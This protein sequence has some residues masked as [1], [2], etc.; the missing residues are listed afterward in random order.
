[1][2]AGSTTD[3]LRRVMAALRRGIPASRVA[4]AAL[5]ALVALPRSAIP[6]IDGDVYWHIRAGLEVL[7]TG[8]VPAEDSWSLVGDG[9]R[10]LS[11]DWLSNVLLGLGWRLGEIGPSVL[12]LA[13]S[14]LVVAALALLWW[15]FGLRRPETGWLGRTGWLTVGL[16]V[17]GPVLGVRVQVV[18]LTLATAVVLSCW[19]YLA[20]PSIGWLVAL[21]TISL[22]WGNLHAG[23]PL[24]FLIG[25]AIVIGEAADQVLKRRPP[26]NM[27][28][29]RQIALLGGALVVSIMPIA[30]NPS[31]LELY[32]YPLETSSI[33]AHRDFISEWQ[34][35]DPGTIV[36]QMFIA[37]VVVIV[38]PS[39]WIG[40][41]T[42][43]AA[44]ALV[45]AGMTVMIALGARFQLLAPIIAATAG[46]ALEPVIA[47]TAVGRWFSKPLARL[48]TARSGAS[49]NVVN[50]ALIGIVVAAGLGVAWARV[51]PTA[52]RELVA[53]HM[54]VGAV[55]WIL[56][57]D[58]GTRPFNQYSWGGYLGL[59][60]PD[61]PIYIDG[62][63]DIY[64]DR[65]IREY[66]NA[67]QLETDPQE[68][69]DRYAIDYILFPPNQPLSQWLEDSPIWQREYVDA[70]AAVWIRSNE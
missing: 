52:Q 11:Q 44:D 69:F 21:P 45:I 24:I 27:L 48:G 8:Q 62:R 15:A 17:A 13:W 36:G 63:S 49:L 41:R 33:A 2:V 14:S 29:W 34:S 39:L 54:P 68:L 35:P 51:S 7:D 59:R 31:G 50:A 5:F 9:M 32:A 20:R 56:A 53:D 3:G 12:S 70:I 18:D 28:T 25:G 57:N 4:I 42:I 30:I 16:I 43:R 66:A 46:L 47:R 23:W 37:F 58:P 19:G 55:N 10:W 64:G 26:H 61:H 22:A 60:R 1:M 65:P 6:L 67:V 40:R 38:L